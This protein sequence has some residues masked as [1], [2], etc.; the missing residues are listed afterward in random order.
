MNQ[1]I[2]FILLGVADVDKSAVF[3]DKIGWKRAKLS[4]PGFIVYHLAGVAIALI[5]RDVLAKDAGVEV[6]T[7]GFKGTA[8]VHLVR[9]VEE[10]SETLEKA[11]KAG[12]TLVKPATVTPYGVA[13]Y[14]KDPDGHLFEVDF[15]EKFEFDAEGRLIL[16]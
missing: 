12:G 2:H 11:V 10:V 7:G 5:G 4:N 16:D 13:G 15:E 9:S 6:G 3:Y 8:L 1:N 14:F